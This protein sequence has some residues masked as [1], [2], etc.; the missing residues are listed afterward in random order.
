MD[1]TVHT[2][3]PVSLME[4]MYLLF[5]APVSRDLKCVFLEM[6]HTSISRRHLEC[7]PPWEGETRPR[8]GGGAK[9]SG[10]PPARNVVCVC[11]YVH[12]HI[13]GGGGG[14][15]KSRKDGEIPG[16]TPSEEAPPSQQ[17]G[18]GGRQIRAQIEKFLGR[19]MEM[20]FVHLVRA[21][22]RSPPSPLYARVWSEEGREGYKIRNPCSSHRRR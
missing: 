11:V 15:S 5:P 20:G 7:D 9:Y 21:F 16:L 17:E 8:R 1:E 6:G 2:R 18:G 10:N 22:V 13:R 3:R 19:E 4:K 14:E 12:T